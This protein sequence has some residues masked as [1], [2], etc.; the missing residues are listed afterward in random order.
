MVLAG[1]VDPMVLYCGEEVI[2]KSVH[3]CIGQAKGK[4]VLNL[5]H[6]MAPFA[7]RCCYAK[8]I[9]FVSKRINNIMVL[10]VLLIVMKGWRRIRQ[11]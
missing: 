11:S 10:I 1:N 2:R 8:W 7:V 5:G 9:R 6:G 3:D 4:H